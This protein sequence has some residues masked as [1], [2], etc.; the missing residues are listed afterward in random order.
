MEGSENKW[1]SN[2]GIMIFGK[3]IFRFLFKHYD[4]IPISR[5]IIIELY[6]SDFYKP[7]GKDFEIRDCKI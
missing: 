4:Y 2:A 6:R 7:S 1:L 3:L 5:D